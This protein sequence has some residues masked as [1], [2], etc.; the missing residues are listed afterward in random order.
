MRRVILGV[1]SAAVLFST[2][3]S[4]QAADPPCFDNANRYVNCGNGTVTDTATG[5]VREYWNPLGRAALPVQDTTT[6]K[7]CP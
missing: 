5:L 1:L 7:V 6:F 2:A 4:V 3:T